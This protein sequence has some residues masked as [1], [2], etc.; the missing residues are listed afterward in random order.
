MERHGLLAG[1]LLTAVPFIAIHIPLL[2]AP[3]WNWRDVG[4]D[5]AVLAALAPFYRYLIGMHLLDTGGSLLAAG[6]QHASWNT[7]QKL[8]AGDWPALVAVIL[9]TITLGL[10]RRLRDNR[11]EAGS[12]AKATR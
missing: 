3:G 4:V 8:G 1:S 2:F 10:A 7:S 9:L 6:I 5:F 12:H 11:A